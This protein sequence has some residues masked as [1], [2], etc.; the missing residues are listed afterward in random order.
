M[1]LQLDTTSSLALTMP[2]EALC[3][4]RYRPATAM[5]ELEFILPQLYL[6][7]FLLLTRINDAY[8][9]RTRGMSF[10]NLDYALDAV[11]RVILTSKSVRIL[12]K[13][14]IVDSLEILY[15]HY[16]QPPSGYMRLEY[17]PLMNHTMT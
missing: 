3:S 7:V 11:V 10:S 15:V 14:S 17:D 16:E 13:I 2:P 4:D 1:W 8:A 5:A 9:A 6:Q 12:I